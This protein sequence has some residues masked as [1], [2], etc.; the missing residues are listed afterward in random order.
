MVMVYGCLSYRRR[1]GG[2]LHWV[3]IVVV[4]LGKEVGVN[5]CYAME[6]RILST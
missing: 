1:V 4:V 3:V 6:A 5:S 2:F